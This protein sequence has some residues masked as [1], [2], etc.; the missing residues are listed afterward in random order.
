MDCSIVYEYE[1]EVEADICNKNIQ[2]NGLGFVG[3]PAW[4]YP[5]E[6]IE[7]FPVDQVVD[8]IMEEEDY[9]IES[10]CS[11]STSMDSLRLQM[12][13]NYIETH[14]SVDVD[15]DLFFSRN[16][17]IVDALSQPPSSVTFHKDTP[18]M[19]K[20]DSDFDDHESTPVEQHSIIHCSS[21]EDQSVNNSL[22]MSISPLSLNKESDTSIR[23]LLKRRRRPDKVSIN[24]EI[25]IIKEPKLDRF[26]EATLVVPFEYTTKHATF[27]IR[28]PYGSVTTPELFQTLSPNV[29]DQEYEETSQV[30][31]PKTIQ[32]AICVAADK[33]MML[34]Y[35]SAGVRYQKTNWGGQ[36][37][38][39]WEDVRNVGLIDVPLGYVHYE[40][41]S[42]T[43]NQTIEYSLDEIL[44]QAMFVREQYCSTVIS[45]ALENEYH[46]TTGSQKAPSPPSLAKSIVSTPP[47]G[48][49]Y[50]YDG[51]SNNTTK[52]EEQ[53]SLKGRK[54]D[55]VPYLSPSL[56]T[57]KSTESGISKR[58]SKQKTQKRKRQV[59]RF[60]QKM[61]MVIGFYICGI[62]LVGSLCG[63]SYTLPTTFL[64]QFLPPS[65]KTGFE[66]FITPTVVKEQEATPDV[67]DM[68]EYY[69]SLQ[70]VEE[71]RDT[72][73]HNLATTQELLWKQVE[74][75][76]AL[77][78]KYDFERVK[79]EELK[80]GEE[81][82]YVLVQNLL[83][84]TETLA[85]DLEIER[86]QRQKLEQTI[87]E[88]EI[89]I[90]TLVKDKAS[91][92]DSERTKPSKEAA[93][94]VIFVDFM[95]AS[96]GVGE[97]RSFEESID[98]THGNEDVVS[99]SSE[100]ISIIENVK[101]IF[102]FN[103]EAGPETDL[104]NDTANNPFLAQHTLKFKDDNKKLR[105]MFKIA[106]E[107]VPE[108]NSPLAAQHSL[109]FNDDN[110][111][112]REMFKKT[113]EKLL[114]EGKERS[115]I[116]RHNVKKHVD[117]ASSS[118]T[119]KIA[120]GQEAIQVVG[121]LAKA[122]LQTAG[123]QARTFLS[124]KWK[125]MRSK[126]I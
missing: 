41:T 26:R 7:F 121:D 58:S 43:G 12:I 63:V 108:R 98:D 112:L 8:D 120:Q 45:T 25:T 69:A 72:Y 60:F 50:Y 39:K 37:S 59:V 79:S 87:R 49:N 51:S 85:E 9:D 14:D 114:K 118:A 82:A 30:S 44:E 61:L 34:L 70:K 56:M 4:D 6:E 65:Y 52:I 110:K 47:R 13:E 74:E 76:K 123:K 124:K 15:F 96:N 101:K 40:K 99:A 97:N 111:K 126:Q 42:D 66:M 92:Q 62:P 31:S 78:E 28:R 68:E 21:N 32:V 27:Y 2:M 46:Q 19:T 106:T 54:L 57:K 3:G 95:D 11:C 35:G 67:P 22:P 10:S 77:A 20:C 105:E 24:N 91:I 18:E 113:T 109:K 1:E 119:L 53:E 73:K 83:V 93:P 117:E 38:E 71:E 116:L 115:G 80:K 84:E 48:N 104:V 64:I 102:L 107:K 89:Q 90:Q 5:E 33:S 88:L 103:H 122:K 16:S 23:L 125:A 86:I 55:F 75:T 81:D 36:R 17:K 94:E 29:T 100:K